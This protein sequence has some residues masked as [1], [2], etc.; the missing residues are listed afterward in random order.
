[1]ARESQLTRRQIAAK[2]REAKAEKRRRCKSPKVK[3]KPTG[4]IRDDETYPVELLEPM[5]G[6]GPS[7]F[8]K[9]VRAGLETSKMGSRKYVS[10]KALREHLAKIAAKQ[11]A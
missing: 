1:M 2:A 9:A 10:G 6:I 7:T 3:A 4:I 8:R 11:E 5:F